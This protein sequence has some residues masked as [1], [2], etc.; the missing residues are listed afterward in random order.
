MAPQQQV[1]LGVAPLSALDVTV[2]EYVVGAAAAGFAA[3]GLRA[4]P[5]LDTDP[6]FPK[7]GSQRFSDLRHLLSDEG[8]EVLD[9]E[10][11]S[12]RPDTV[13]D[14]W[15]P[16]LDAGQQL[17]A[18]LLNIV[19]DHPSLA[20]F[21]EIM[22]ELTA[23]AQT[24]GIVPV[25]E[26]VA[27][28][29]LND[30]PKSVEIA[31]AVG[32]KVELDLLHFMR[33][34]A[35]LEFVEE[36]REMFPI[37]QLCDAPQDILSIRE[38]LLPHAASDGKQDLMMAESRSMRQLPGE[39]DAPIDQVLKILGEEVPVSVE[40]PNAAQRG[41]LDAAAYLLLLAEHA[42]AFLSG[43]PAITLPG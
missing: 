20:A 17:G 3:V 26:P 4:F 22:T 2:E 18:S 6:Q 10:V 28:R 24:F 5:V 13:R 33:T 35:T 37:L 36:H 8:I 31:R 9:L 32:C 27:Y 29:H 11:F 43:A 21:E 42:R 39:G 40:I 34:G 7:L 38:A 41:D 19:G 12:V 14:T 25:L 1:K 15:L 23:D 16:V 30:Y